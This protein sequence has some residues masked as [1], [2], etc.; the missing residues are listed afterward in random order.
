MIN[1]IIFHFSQY[2]FCCEGYCLSLVLCIACIL[3]ILLHSAIGVMMLPVCLSVSLSKSS[4]TM[5][6]VT[7][8]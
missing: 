5:C 7:K 3:P 2:L 6:V 1:H 8:R 4:M